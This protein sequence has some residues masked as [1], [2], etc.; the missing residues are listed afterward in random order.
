MR[1]RTLGPPWFS[2][3]LLVAS[4]GCQTANFE[5]PGNSGSIPGGT[6]TGRQTWEE[7]AENPP[8]NAR[9]DAQVFQAI[10]VNQPNVDC[11]QGFNYAPLYEHAKSLAKSLAAETK[12]PDECAPAHFWIEQMST[13][14]LG[15][16]AAVNMEAGILCPR[17]TTTR[18]AGVS[19]SAGSLVG[20]EADFPDPLPPPKPRIGTLRTKF[21]AAFVG[22]N[23]VEYVLFDYREAVGDCS[24]QTYDFRAHV[25]YA[26]RRAPSVCG[27][28]VCAPG[29]KDCTPPVIAQTKWSCRPN[30]REVR[31][32]VQVQCCKP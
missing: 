8:R 23:P 9:C 2:L 5:G 16:I 4:L 31:V 28:A 20:P 7:N 10:N 30:G 19:P 18:P 24:G 32:E 17:A 13:N 6:V 1:T 27:P 11:E 21:P 15:T 14:C 22:C 3:L 29:C 12:C 25:E 26:Q